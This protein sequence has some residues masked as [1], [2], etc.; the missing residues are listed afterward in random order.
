MFCRS[1]WFYMIAC[2]Y[3]IMSLVSHNLCKVYWLLYS[4]NKGKISNWYYYYKPFHTRDISTS[5]NQTGRCTYKLDQ[6]N[7]YLFACCAFAS[8]E[9][10]PEFPLQE[11]HYRSILTTFSTSPMQTTIESLPTSTLWIQCPPLLNHNSLNPNSL[12]YIL[13]SEMQNTVGRATGIHAI[14]V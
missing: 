9:E 3:Y 6:K 1:G 14:R 8:C 10:G 11:Y 12:T 7:W 5:R 13:I 4:S 2:S